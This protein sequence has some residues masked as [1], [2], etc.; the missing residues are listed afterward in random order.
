MGGDFYLHGTEGVQSCLPDMLDYA[1]LE[2]RLSVRSPPPY[3]HTAVEGSM[4]I[5]PEA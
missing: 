2:T 5:F 3:S 4:D 1:R